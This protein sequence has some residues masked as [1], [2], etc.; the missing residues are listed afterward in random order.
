MQTKSCRGKRLRKDTAVGGLVMMVTTTQ[1]SSNGPMSRTLPSQVRVP[2]AVLG[3]SAGDDEEDPGVCLEVRQ[4]WLRESPAYTHRRFV[5]AS[6]P[7]A[8]HVGCR[9]RAF[10]RAEGSVALQCLSAFPKYVCLPFPP[11]GS[12][13]AGM[14]AWVCAPF[15]TQLPL[16]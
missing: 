9:H 14:N 4:R 16:A 2:S 11:R 1:R 12:P 10:P 15:L 7:V 13:H 5:R 6:P 8:A 3:T